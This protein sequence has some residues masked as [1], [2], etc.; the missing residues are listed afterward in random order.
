M[1]LLRL[2]ILLPIFLLFILQT[3]PT[4]AQ[5]S[6]EYPVITAENAD[7]LEE[8]AVWGRGT[9]HD[10]EWSPKD[11]WIAVSGSRGVWLLDAHDLTAEPLLL[12]GHTDVVMMVAF[13]PDG[14]F[15]ASVSR[16]GTVRIW[17]LATFETVH[18][19]EDANGRALDIS[20]EG[21]YLAYSVSPLDDI[22][23]DYL[24]VVN[25][26]THEELFTNDESFGS[27]T[28]L[29]FA[30][31]GEYLYVGSQ[32]ISDAPG[33]GTETIDLAT[34]EFVPILRMPSCGDKKIQGMD[35][36]YC[37]DADYEYYGFGNLETAYSFNRRVLTSPD[38]SWFV[39]QVWADGYGTPD[40]IRVF[41]NQTGHLEYALNHTAD[42]MEISPD[43]Q[44]LLTL[45]GNKLYFWNIATGELNYI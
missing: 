13:H 23:D 8:I 37:T 36:D 1:K 15:L 4:T 19:F 5:E 33:W 31:D 26:N 25:W 45:S 28:A 41:D 38:Q 29:E 43:S 14:E 42:R 10:V 2:L 11:D 39:I 17:D 27:V 21:K 30:E 44:T 34:G 9:I 32:R 24:R 16:D 7:Q 6:P 3:I 18:I 40:N 22:W 12:E 20:P 35:P